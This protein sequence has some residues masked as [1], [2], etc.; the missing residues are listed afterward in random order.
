MTTK[1]WFI[2][3]ASSGFGREFTRAAIARGD[4]VAG[5]S[6]EISRLD[7]LATEFGEAFLP[8]ELDIVDR[9]ADFE[10]VRRAH[11]HFGRLDIIVNN[12]GYGQ[13]GVVEELTEAEAR[14]QLDTNFFGALWVTQAALPYLREQG[15]G[16][17]VQVSSVGGHFSAP[18]L[19]IYCS[20][21]WALEALS[22]ALAGEVAQFGIRVTMIEPGGFATQAEA[23]AGDPSQPNDAYGA[24]HDVLQER[25]SSTYGMG[26]TLGDPRAGAEALLAIVDAED[27]PLR[28]LFGT[29]GLALVEGEYERRLEGWRASQRYTDLSAASTVVAS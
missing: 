13:Y 26:A 17:I 1:T 5:T 19:G 18:S 14:R 9:A 11:E 10:A 25:R 27:P 16:Q 21:K 6:R 29:G 20:S 4:R 3:G 28:V 23:S 24:E 15:G 8:L 2:S 12:A 7:D 22:Q